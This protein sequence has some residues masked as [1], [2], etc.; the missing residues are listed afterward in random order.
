MHVH[1]LETREKR[2]RERRERK[3]VDY[4]IYYWKER[5]ES[6]REKKPFTCHIMLRYKYVSIDDDYAF[7]SLS[8]EEYKATNHVK[9]KTLFIIFRCLI[10]HP[11][12]WTAIGE[13]VTARAVCITNHLFFSIVVVIVVVVVL[14]IIIIIVITRAILRRRIPIGQLTKRMSEIDR[15]LLFSY[16][17]CVWNVLLLA[18]V[19][20]M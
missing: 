19:F 2:E 13:C 16:R 6:E 9:E 15:E 8:L 17:F 1:C 3:T 5:R 11:D 14:I 12:Q 18:A 10:N 7:H 4:G 20:V